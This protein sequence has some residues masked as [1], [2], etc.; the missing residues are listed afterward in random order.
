[1][2]LEKPEIKDEDPRAVFVGDELVCMDCMTDE[3]WEKVWFG[4]VVSSDYLEGMGDSYCDRCRKNLGD[5]NV[6][7][8][9]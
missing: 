7:K 9:N 4:C 6:E 8:R 5:V 3:D 2:K 1:M